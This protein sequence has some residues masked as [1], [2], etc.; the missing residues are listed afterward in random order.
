MANTRFALLIQLDPGKLVAHLPSFR[1]VTATPHRRHLYATS[2]PPVRNHHLVT[3]DLT[4]L[5][6]PITARSQLR[7]PARL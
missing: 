6:C 3:A 5:E 4:L 7:W 1:Q 2:T